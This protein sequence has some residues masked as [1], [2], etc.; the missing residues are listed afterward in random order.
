MQAG[1]IKTAKEFYEEYG[2]AC[3]DNCSHS[4][5]CIVLNADGEDKKELRKEFQEQNINFRC[6]IMLGI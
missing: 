2:F 1:R 6:P 4:G 5:G 3:Y